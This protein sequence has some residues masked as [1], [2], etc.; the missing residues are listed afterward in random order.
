[1][2]NTRKTATLSGR[3]VLTSDG[4]VISRRHA[5]AEGYTIIR[6]GGE[7]A[8]EAASRRAAEY[9]ALT[10]PSHDAVAQAEAIIR[11]GAARRNETAAPTSGIDRNGAALDP[12]SLA[13]Q[14]VKAA[15]RARGED[16]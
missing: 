4:R 10:E 1:M 16:V 15:A 9:R 8:A 12:D 2:D 13:S 7:T 3:F 11:A 5:E 14:I 6:S